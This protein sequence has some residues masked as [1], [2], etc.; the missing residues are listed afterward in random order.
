M[1]KSIQLL[2]IAILVASLAAC[3][4]GGNADNPSGGQGTTGNSGANPPSKEE[5]ITY[6]I[7]RNFNAP[8][9]PADGGPARQIILE[10]LK[11]AGI[12]G[13]DYQVQLATGEE[14]TTKLNLLASSDELPDFFSIDIQT[15]T[16]YA[17]EGLIIPL[18]DLL[19][20]APDLMKF[21]RREDLENLKYKGKIYGL[22]VGYRPEPFNG[23]NV[24]GLVIRK[25]WLDNLG[26]EEPKTLDELHEV[27]RAFTY[28]D[29]DQNG[30]DDTYG[31]S[32]TKTTNFNFVFGAFGII[33]THKDTIFW[34][35]RDGKLRPG[36]VLP[37]AKE[38]LA[39][40]QQWYKEGLIDPE[41]PVMETKQ[42]QEKVINSKVGLY[43]STAFDGDPK[44]P[45]NASLRQAAPGA[46]LKVIAPPMGP[47]GHKGLPENS[48]SY[49]D[50]RS[51]SAKAPHPEKLMELINWSAGPG[52]NLVTYGVEGKHYVEDKANNKINMLVESYSDLY[53]EG[54]SNPIRFVQIVDRRWMAD[55]AI[56]GMVI[57][58]D[59]ENL[60]KNA[61]WKT[62]P[63]ML[64]YPDLDKLWSEY[65]AK[66]VTGSYSVDKWDEFVERF[67]SQGGEIIEQQVNEEWNK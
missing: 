64:D 20:Q 27:L 4:S 3:S 43:E 62:V 40:L 9:Y 35:E 21:I 67:Y 17:D 16:R 54:F 7:F 34:T 1:K 53:R 12:E 63:A 11:K 65:F 44:Q 57:T 18:D 37:E 5:T 60:I 32:G 41:F 26:L 58:N 49:G 15:M 66:I 48:P 25:D 24:D 14:Y 19:A 29:P 2:L 51:I 36:F 42:L 33:P 13:V 38:A 31:L 61:F 28:D 52:F 39:L 10:E 22:P 46:V 30:K 56:E 47:D 50:I 45:I 59:P 8:E 55:E 23:P 6:H